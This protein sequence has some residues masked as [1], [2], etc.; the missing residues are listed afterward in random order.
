MDLRLV[1]KSFCFS[2]VLLILFSFGLRAQ[3]YTEK[4][5]PSLVPVD[6]EMVASVGGEVIISLPIS[7]GDWLIQ[8]K[9]IDNILKWSANIALE[10]NENIF[11]TKIGSD[12][13]N[14]YSTRFN[15]NE[16]TSDLFIISLDLNS[17]KLLEKKKLWTKTVDNAIRDRNK[18]KR[19]ADPNLEIASLK[20]LN[21]EVPLEFRFEVVS[22]ENG[23]FTLLS[24]FDFSKNNLV[25]SYKIFGDD[26]NEIESKDLNLD[27]LV[28]LYDYGIDNSGS[29]YHLNQSFEGDIQLTQFPVKSND[30]NLLTLTAENSQRDDL[31]LLILGEGRVVVAGKA[32][33]E[34][35]FYGCLYAVF[36]FNELAVDRIHFES[37]PIDFKDAADSLYQLGKMEVRDWTNYTLTKLES[38][39]DEELLLVFEAFDLRRSGYVFKDRRFTSELDW[40]NH[41]TKLISGPAMVFSFDKNDELRWSKYIYKRLEYDKDLASASNFYSDSPK[42][43][44]ITFFANSDS[45]PFEYQM[46]YI[47][48]SWY[49]VQKNSGG[50][51]I[52]IFETVD[53]NTYAVYFSE[54]DS[55]LIIQQK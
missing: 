14:F 10:E 4:L 39:N 40:E 21:A 17:G 48:N 46:D 12:K 50:R 38:Y 34:N 1:I 43:E 5:D 33:I 18:A 35:S 20:P 13:I 55:N 3:V 26:F 6:F 51:L 32:E 19:I 54:K 2:A 8:R 11:T 27:D 16:R 23:H 15:L 42:N 29:L 53:G 22:S 45:G 36:D 25:H 47:Y 52:S 9:G 30:Y 37:L 31:K 24:F 28:Y 41:K 44:K 7:R 49:K